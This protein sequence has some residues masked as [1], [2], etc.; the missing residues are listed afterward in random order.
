M[1][2]M[3]EMARDLVR[4]SIMED[5]MAQFL[6][7]TLAFVHDDKIKPLQA[8]T[9]QLER[10]LKEAVRALQIARVHVVNNECGWSVK[11][12]AARFD[13]GVIDHIMEKIGASCD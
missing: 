1:S 3:R 7:Q 5:A 12:E 13:L 9:E 6:A 2:K 4:E 11:R 8:R 10:D